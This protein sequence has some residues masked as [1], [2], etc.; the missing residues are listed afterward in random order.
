M[1]TD[2]GRRVKVAGPSTPVSPSPH[3]NL[4][5]G[6][7]LCGL[8]SAVRAAGEERA[9]R[10]PSHQ[11]QRVSS[12]KSLIPVLVNKLRRNVHQG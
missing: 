7:H 2:L 1:T 5:A 6:D 11:R 8:R 12:E 10:A 9:K 4:M 3:R